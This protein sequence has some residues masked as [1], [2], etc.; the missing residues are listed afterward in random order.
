MKGE[1][2]VELRELNAEVNHRG[3]VSVKGMT[4]IDGEHCLRWPR[5]S[6]CRSQEFTSLQFP[7]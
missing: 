6:G 4:N 7:R 5:T 1:I 3:P 2:F